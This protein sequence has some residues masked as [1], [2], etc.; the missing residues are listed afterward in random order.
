M[1]EPR[2]K[3]PTPSTDRQDDIIETGAARLIPENPV[4]HR[5]AASPFLAG[6]MR[7]CD[8]PTPEELEKK[9]KSR[10]RRWTKAG[11]KAK[12]NS[13]ENL[14]VSEARNLVRLA[15]IEDEANY[16]TTPLRQWFDDVAMAL[17][18]AQRFPRIKRRLETRRGAPSLEEMHVAGRRLA[19]KYQELSNGKPVRCSGTKRAWE[20]NRSDPSTRFI[21]H[22]L[23]VFFPEIT[24][25]QILTVFQHLSKNKDLR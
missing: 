1:G 11:L 24:D 2:K 3:K 5:A 13:P 6:T 10:D 8:M 21:A 17:L 19:E 12:R 9:N 4:P 23:K 14:G 22:G 20:S 16:D 25:K 18:A 7:G 15:G